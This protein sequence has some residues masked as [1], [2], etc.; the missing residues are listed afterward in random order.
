MSEIL[1]LIIISLELTF[2]KVD[3]LKGVKSDEVSVMGVKVGN[4]EKEV[5]KRLGFP[6]FKNET[7][8]MWIYRN[9]IVYFNKEGRVNR[10]S[11]KKSFKEVVK[12]KIRKV[13]SDSIFKDKKLREALLGQEIEV[14]IENIEMS[15]IKVEKWKYNFG[16]GIVIE[17]A[18]KGE[19]YTFQ[20]LNL[21]LM[22]DKK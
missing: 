9:I 15:K 4:H 10:L 2:G 12:G 8:R 3:T 11:L 22:D 18:R 17:G 5:I 20:F 16:N 6:L 13:F 19:E 1:I 14:S 7:Q 21:I